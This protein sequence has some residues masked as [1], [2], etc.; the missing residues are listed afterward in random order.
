G[1]THPLTAICLAIFMFSLTGLPPLAGFW[2][3]LSLFLGALSIDVDSPSTGLRP[4]FVA[5]AVIGALNA[6][7]SA[8]Y[9]L[10]VV[11]VMYFRSPVNIPRAEGGRGAW[12]TGAVAAL[13][14]V[15]VGLVSEPVLSSARRA[16]TSLRSP[17]ATEP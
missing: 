15:G 1:Q 5:L 8:G 7:I 6:A 13:L 17:A 9:Y 11:G 16:S 12:L 14:V 2:G 4:W 3:K 10:R